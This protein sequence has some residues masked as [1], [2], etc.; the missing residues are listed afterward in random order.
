MAPKEQQTKPLVSLLAGGTAGA[1]EATAT[2]PFEFA[3]T[4]VQLRSQGRASVNPFRVVAQVFRNEG[5]GALY[6]GCSTMV[7]GTVAKDSIRFLTFDVIKGVFA[8][9]ETGSLSPMGNLLSG[10]CAGVVVSTFPVTPTERVKTAMIDDA[11]SEKR[12][13]S[14]VHAVRVLLQENGPWALYRGYVTTTVKQAGATAFRLG[15]YNI[16]KD[17]ETKRD[18][19]QNTATNFANGATA[20]TITTYATQPIDTVKT[21]VQSAKGAGTIEA[22][23][24]IMT[25]D[26]ILGFW[27]GSTMRLGRT[28]LSGGILFTVFEQA[29]AILDPILA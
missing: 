4:R 28:V 13:R 12:F 7:V 2:Y 9:P 5:L 22:I 25:D 6:T 27:R 29:V 20:G 16:L 10:M 21:R 19:P 11:R 18:I 3:K 8:D 15:S 1:V 23:T 14:P 17:F 26:G 24:S